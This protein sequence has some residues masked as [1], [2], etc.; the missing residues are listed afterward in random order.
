MN[1]SRSRQVV[2]LATCGLALWV[3]R[4]QRVQPCHAE[5]I[6]TSAP[7]GSD[8]AVEAGIRV[9]TFPAEVRAT[10]TTRD[11]LPDN[12][13]LAVV[14][15][16]D[17][18]VYAGTAAG[19]AR[20]DGSRWVPVT[21]YR[22][23]VEL[24]AR[25][26]GGLIGTAAGGLYALQNGAVSRLADLPEV[27]TRPDGLRS[28]AGGVKVLLGTGAGLFEL[29]DGAFVPVRQLNELLGQDREVRQVTQADDGRIAVAAEAGLLEF[30][31]GQGWEA[32]YPRQ[33]ERSWAPRDVRGV[34]FDRRG[35]LCFACPQGVG[36]RD[37][38]QWRLYTGYD[39]LPYNDFTTA[40]AGEDGVVWFGTKIGAI[41]FDGQR[42]S[43]RMAP[44]WLP[45]DP[46]RAVA[47]T[48]G[49]DAW[50]ATAKGVGVIQRQPL[51]LA[52][53]ARRFE[54]AIDKYHRRTPYGFVLSV[55][56]GKPGDTSQWVQHDSDNDGLWTGMY[57]AG[58][59]FA[60]AATK[61]P[62]ARKRATD[63]FEALRFL[64]QVTQG[65]AHPAPRGFPARTVLPT[66]GPDPNASQYTAEK[67]RRTQQRDPLW[68]VIVPRWPTSADGKWYWKCDTSSDELDGHYFL[69]ALYYDLVAETDAE[70]QRV[71]DVVVAITDHL[72][73]HNFQLFDHDGK[74]TRWGRFSPEDLNGDVIQGARGLN[75]LSILSY[76]K[77]AEHMT[78][79][80][81]YRKAYDTL[82]QVHSYAT[83][84]LDP[85][86]RTGP[87]TGNQSDD[88]MAAMC[89]YNLIRYETDPRLSRMYHWS[90][91]WHWLV[92]APERCPLFNFIFAALDDGRRIPFLK[93]PPR[94]SILADAVDTL[95]RIPLDRIR[96]SFRNSHRTDVV[97]LPASSYRVHRGGH[98]RDGTVV[99]VDERDLE[100]WNQDPW[101]LDAAHDGRTLT[102]G[103]AFL[104]PY[105][106]G[107]YQGY[108]KD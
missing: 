67:D 13:I 103:S 96:W 62:Q 15:D 87:G 64:S 97:M 101:S 73:D 58:E 52:E 30:R 57:G 46:V 106:M 16:N 34:V 18:S 81:K 44:R 77:V 22:G 59:C 2:L 40:A 86:R 53:K 76:L 92:E 94:K 37:S 35:R 102:D 4:V 25:H 55:H 48:A 49:G 84:T 105:Y 56:L 104:L 20:Y 21:D 108:I 47:V 3:Q 28:L 12:D 23:P 5:Q 14:I 69:Y 6:R 98:L 11:G 79:D 80:P 72:I 24:L 89:Y 70:K 93:L 88:E 38:Q 10:Y 60:Y 26:R 29:V 100:Y 95:K 107:L 83:N 75:S 91:R 32:I 45:D 39:G 7:G 99:P 50:F 61:D 8:S 71:R 63:A 1:S 33:A 78:G 68:K 90:L 51:T 19:L 66:S 65:G 42:W 41:R 85:K 54:A 74:A 82:V 43:Y 31:P 9:G 36:V 27:A 17:D